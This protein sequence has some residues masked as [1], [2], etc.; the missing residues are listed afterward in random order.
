M[1]SGRGGI[2][3]AA[4][5]ATNP[6]IAASQ[7]AGSDPARDSPKK[8]KAEKETAGKSLKMGEAGFEPA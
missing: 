5:L 1:Q 4:P 6:P 7:Q 2:S 3:F 8:Q